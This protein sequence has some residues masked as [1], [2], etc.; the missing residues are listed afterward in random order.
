MTKRSASQAET[1]TT[2][3]PH[4]VPSL[5]RPLAPTLALLSEDLLQALQGPLSALASLQDPFALQD[6]QDQGEH[7]GL[8]GL[9]NHGDLDRLAA[10][11]WLLQSELPEEFL[12]RLLDREALYHEPLYENPGKRQ[13]A[14]L[15][16]DASPHSLGLPRI[17]QLA[18]LLH[19]GALAQRTQVELRWTIAGAQPPAAENAKDAWQSGINHATLRWLLSSSVLGPLTREDYQR[20]FDTLP[21][22][23]Q[24]TPAATPDTTPDTS[25]PLDFVLAPRASVPVLPDS[26]NLLTFEPLP[27]DPA[28][29]AGLSLQQTL[30]GQATEERQLRLPGDGLCLAALRRPLKPEVSVASLE[31]GRLDPAAWPKVD[32]EWALRHYA[33]ATQALAV[34]RHDGRFLVLHRDPMRSFALRLNRS[35][36]LAG[37][38][39][40]AHSL[41]LWL[42]GDNGRADRFE[43]RHYKLHQGHPVGAPERRFAPIASGQF[44]KNFGPFDLPQLTASDLLHAT[45]YSAAHRRYLS[46]FDPGSTKATKDHET[47]LVLSA[48]SHHALMTGSQGIRICDLSGA[49]A[50]TW[51]IVKASDSF[52]DDLVTPRSFL[53][54]AK[55]QILSLTNNGRRWHCFR[56]GRALPYT[57]LKEDHRAL[58]FLFEGNNLTAL[59]YS[60]PRLG[61]DGQLHRLIC[62]TGSLQG[63]AQRDLEGPLTQVRLN[64]KTGEV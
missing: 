63:Q 48:N 31:A 26:I 34:A 29:Q 9:N 61:G 56:P 50:S 33:F 41:M 36:L 8:S 58:R 46:H 39:L 6:F 38:R 52:D 23:A 19:L 18:V 27:R 35:D 20:Q 47:N 40:T 28:G 42:R 54:E 13:I 21:L 22:V 2:K 59:V 44:A 1:Q 10:S 62:A 37:Y 45:F 4:G 64:P 60:D 30:A 12:R 17:L 57:L 55:Q 32:T 15:L 3:L 14:R 5:Y 7:A 49:R 11:E 43:M 25:S 53:F 51:P 24:E 16:L